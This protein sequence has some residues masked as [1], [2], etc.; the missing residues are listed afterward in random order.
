MISKIV[1]LHFFLKQ[2]ITN[3]SIFLFVSIISDV[4]T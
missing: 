3:I 2:F 4:G 1:I